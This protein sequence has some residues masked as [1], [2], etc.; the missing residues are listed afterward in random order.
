M[1]K[2]MI[3]ILVVITILVIVLSACERSATSVNTGKPTATSEIPFPVATQPQIMVD[4]LKGT[5]T[6][7]ALSLTPQTGGGLATTSTPSFAYSTPVAAAGTAVAVSTAAPAISN[8]PYPTST[9][10]KPATWTLQE[11]EYPYCIARRFNVDPV[12]LL[13]MNGMTMDSL[14]VVGT[15][16]K[17]PTSGT[18]PGTRARVA[19]PTTYS[20][21]T[22]ETVYQ[23]ACKFGDVDP[24]IILAANGLTAGTVL[25]S[26]QVLQIP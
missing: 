26:G 18:F 9:P 22:G 21:L 11:G 13:T 8:T 2:K 12:D 17:I 24:N 25:T 23:I 7:A 6:A 14:P 15:S 1:N 5:Q 4:I 10:G 3:G 20:V 19:H 16:L